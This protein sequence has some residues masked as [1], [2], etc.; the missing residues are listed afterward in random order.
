MSWEVLPNVRSKLQVSAQRPAKRPV[1]L[2]LGPSVQ[3]IFYSQKGRQQHKTTKYRKLHA[4]QIYNSQENRELFILLLVTSLLEEGTQACLSYLWWSLHLIFLVLLSQ[5][6]RSACEEGRFLYFSI[7]TTF[8]PRSLMKRHWFFPQWDP[9][10]ADCQQNLE[11]T[12]QCLPSDTPP[13]AE[14]STESTLFYTN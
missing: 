14:I 12:S 10:M 6:K 8:L 1:Q 3:N 2:L 11:T 9:N 4:T 5:L 7:N 13:I